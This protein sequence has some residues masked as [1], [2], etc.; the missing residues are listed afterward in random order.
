VFRPLL[1]CAIGTVAVSGAAVSLGFRPCWRRFDGQ[2]AR[3]IGLT[4][5]TSPLA[6]RAA[7]GAPIPLPFGSVALREGG[8]PWARLLEQVDI[9]VINHGG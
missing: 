3:L 1:P 7:P 2:G 5:Q 8:R 9:L 4:S 6:S